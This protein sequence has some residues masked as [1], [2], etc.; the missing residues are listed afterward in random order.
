MIVIAVIAFIAIIIFGIIFLI[1][2]RKTLNNTNNMS[3]PGLSLPQEKYGDDV[4]F[5]K[6]SYDLDV[7]TKRRSSKNQYGNR[8][9]YDK[10]SYDADACTCGPLTKKSY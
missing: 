5:D 9:Y 1:K 3:P 7:G 2:K 4:Y 6:L 10:L 8:I